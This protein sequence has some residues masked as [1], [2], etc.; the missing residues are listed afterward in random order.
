MRL[1]L[2]G[3]PQAGKSTLFSAITGHKAD[4]GHAAAEQIASLAVPDERL[5]YLFD[6]YKPKK[7]SPAHLELVD[8]PGHSLAEPHGQAA[9][10]KSMDVVRRCD[11]IVMVLRAFESDSVAK[12]RDRVDAKADLEELHTELI[13]SDL[14]QVMNRIQKLEKAIQKP[15]KTRDEEV[16]ELAMMHRV[17]KALEAEK[18]VAGE[19]HNEE[20]RGIATSF[21]FLTLKPVV[22]VINVGEGDAAKP[23]PFQAKYA[24]ETISLSAE[25]EGEILQLPAED[26]PA[27]LADMGLA[28]PASIRL[29]NACYKG[30]GLISFLTVGGDEVRAWTIK[31]GTP[32]IEAAGKIHTD[33][34]RGFIKAEVVPF[35]ELKAHKDFK[36]AKNAGKARLESKHYVVQDGDVIDFRFNV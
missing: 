8:Q 35:T 3:P 6:V 24:E 11:G 9:F 5:T 10:R 13:F 29:I 31:R 34:Q 30:L 27:F 12:Y 16:R 18:P 1:A 25:I 32:A 36:G 33:I 26:R 2:V 7:R 4:P 15:S 14:E 28:E 19:I 20:E 22:V 21:G 17:Q 23:P